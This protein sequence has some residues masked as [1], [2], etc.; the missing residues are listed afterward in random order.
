MEKKY[1]RAVFNIT[2]FDA[3]DVITTS[4]FTPEIPANP[5]DYIAVD[6]GSEAPIN[7][8]F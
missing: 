1:E 8:W 2:A 4:G 3:E 6:Y 5:E 7:D